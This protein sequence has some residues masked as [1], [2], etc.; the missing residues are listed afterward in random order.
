MIPIERAKPQESA[1]NPAQ[2]TPSEPFENI[3]QHVERLKHIRAMMLELRKTLN[4]N[5]GEIVTSQP[6]KEDTL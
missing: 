1:E 3:A 2:E 6:K 4:A 5:M